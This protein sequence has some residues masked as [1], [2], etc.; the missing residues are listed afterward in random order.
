MIAE[1]RGEVI[2]RSTPSLRTGS[3][4]GL[5]SACESE[6]EHLFHAIARFGSALKIIE[7]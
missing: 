2:E 5:F 1:A 6:R 4:I 3:L 7:T